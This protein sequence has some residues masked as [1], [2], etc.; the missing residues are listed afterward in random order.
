MESVVI[1][2]SMGDIQLE[3]YWDH[4]PRVGLS[5]RSSM[6]IRSPH[7]RSCAIDMQEFFGARKTWLLQ[8]G[9]LPP[10]RRCEFTLLRLYAFEADKGP[11]LMSFTSL[12]LHDTDR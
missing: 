1:E 6:S 5:I 8:R 12:G 4:A 7:R 9:R 11:D 10:Y 3:L 2:T